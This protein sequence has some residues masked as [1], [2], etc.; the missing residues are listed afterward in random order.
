M[1]IER[2]QKKIKYDTLFT[3]WPLGNSQKYKAEINVQADGMSDK[4]SQTNDAFSRL[5]SIY[6]TEN[7]RVNL[8]HKRSHLQVFYIAAILKNLARFLDKTLL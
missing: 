6:S 3:D 4:H 2:K 8:Y 5:F 7:N 1:K